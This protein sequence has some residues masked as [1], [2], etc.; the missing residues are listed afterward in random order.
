VTGL[1]SMRSRLR[2]NAAV[3]LAAGMAV[4]L[5][6]RAA[7]VLAD[8]PQTAA[9]VEPASGEPT[10]AEIAAL[11]GQLGD[12]DY[13]VRETASTRLMEL[14]PAA[15]D[16]VLTAAEV[17]GD[18]EVAMRARWLADTLPLVTA[19]DPPEVVAMLEP[20]AGSGYDERVRIMHRLLRLDDDAGIEPLARIVRLE[21][22]PA[23]SRIAAAL[24][25]R[26]WQPDDPYWPGLAP[27]ILAGVGSSGRPAARL[28]RG[29]VAA[30]T[31]PAPAEAARGLEEVA[32]TTAVMHP[33]DGG[34]E[35]LATLDDESA[36]IAR[37]GRI[38]RRC[39]TELLARAEHRKEA[40]LEA[41]QLLAAVTG[42][43]DVASQQAVELQ[44]LAMHGLPEAVDLVAE[45]LAA[46]DTPPLLAYAAAVAWRAR[47]EP[48]AQVR[49]AVIARGAA[50]RLAAE[51]EFTSRL[52]IAMVLA[53]WGADDWA[54]REYRGI[55]DNEASPRATRALTAILCSEFLHDRQRHADAA[56]VLRRV[57]EERGGQGDDIEGALMQIERDPRSVKSRML[58]FS[59][60]AAAAAG[61]NVR[62]RQLL[63]ES[64]RAYSKDV[65]TLIASYRL[66]DN[67]PAQQ[68]EAAI[69]VAR[70]LAAIEEEIRA[71]P[72]DPNCRNEYA[73]LV[74][75]TEGD[76]A[77]AIEY[78]RA[79]LE[80]SF[81]SA[82]Y[83]DTLAHC[84]AAAG[85]VTR[86]VRTQ[87]LALKQEPHGQTLRRNLDR[88]QT[89]AA[90][91]APAP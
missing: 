23:G 14:G 6:G 3:L 51:D 28:L 15:A 13:A 24:L 84:H 25:V 43:A 62:Q 2:G 37:T 71:L 21:R 47:A 70:G 57:L 76:V 38:F 41:A 89:Q 42:E 68:A 7:D 81:D 22:T 18:L 64:L 33:S 11:V 46:G 30:T 8:L 88:F 60:C 74:A 12:N 1:V 17:S 69:R 39:L 67:T 48:A 27:R 83:L 53:R 56:D 26:E 63:E 82:S 65:D 35:P 4:V 91:Q 49:A 45:Q 32:A 52:Q 55:L 75:N 5:A 36:G 20:F 40:V 10:E 78:S 73:W 19:Q 79:S 29:L 16:A 77:R 72:D 9:A 44:W 59:A 85:D 34:D 66:P 54:E 87:W 50:E 90:G 80:R 61:D 86:A 58:Y 31:A